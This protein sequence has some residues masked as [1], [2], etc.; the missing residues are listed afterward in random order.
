M[1]EKAHLTGTETRAIE[2]FIAAT[3][4]ADVRQAQATAGASTELSGSGEELFNRFGC[5]GCHQVDGDGGSM[6]PDL[7][8]TYRVKGADFMAQ[9][10]LNPALGNPSSTMP[11]FPLNE[12]EAQAVV[13]YISNQGD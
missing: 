5:K 9:K 6:G 3:L 1:R 13:E 8:E 2:R 7:N 11:K 10:I 4:T 12:R